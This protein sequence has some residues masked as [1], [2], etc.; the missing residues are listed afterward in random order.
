MSGATDK[1]TIV[2]ACMRVDGTPAFA[3]TV[4]CVTKEE[5]ENG[6]HYYLAEIELQALGFE[7]PYVHFSEDE[8]PAFLFPAVRQFLET[9][10]VVPDRII[11][12]QSE[13]PK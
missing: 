2:T 4:V 11:H 9:E 10:S 5:A 7:E 12:A 1:R 13:K 3:L 6:V 8:S